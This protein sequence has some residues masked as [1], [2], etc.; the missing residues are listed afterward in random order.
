MSESKKN[1]LI[2]WELIATNP[3]DKNWN[4]KDIFFYWSVNVQSIIGFSLIASLFLLYQLNTVVVFFGTILG[5]LL[6][7]FFTNIIGSP[8]QQHGIPFVVFLRTSLGFNGAKCLG[9][10]R[11]VVGIFTFGIQT[12]F[13]SKAISYLIRILFFSIDNNILDNEIFLIFLMGLN[14]IDWFSIFI[15]IIFQTLFFKNGINYSK[16]I[17]KF[18]A[19]SVYLGLFLFFLI[20]LLSDVKL[21]TQVFLESLKF[22]N[23]LSRNNVAPF[24]TVTGTIFAYFSILIISYGDFAKNISNTSEMKKGNLSLLFNLIIFS[25]FA[26]FIT[27]GSDIFLKDDA[28]A[29]VKILT[30]PTDIIGKLDNTTITVI[31]LIFIILG[32]ASTNLVANFIPSQFTL[33]NLFPKK[34]NLFNSSIIISLVGFFVAILWLTVLS[35]IGILAFIDTFASI[36]GPLFG[37]ILIDY[38]FIK[39]RILNLKDLHSNEYGSSYYYTKGWNFKATYCLL[40]GFIFSASTIWNVNMMYFQS[41]SWIIGAF[42]SSL[43]YYLLAKK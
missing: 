4:W 12:F 21:T 28:N 43:T 16:K 29:I 25:F 18:S 26:V 37:V 6:V 42:I 27:I 38:Y 17:I 14:V 11:F 22:D 24:F 2:N 9:A 36:F 23:F 32:S 40:L 3:S 34:L 35:Q 10:L 20:V 33:I 39:K 8:S 31:A 41:Y 1:D 15:T 30:N 13:L 5:G 19:I 7:W